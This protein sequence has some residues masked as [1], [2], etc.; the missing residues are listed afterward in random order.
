MNYFP[1]RAKYVTP[2][3]FLNELRQVASAVVQAFRRASHQVK[4]RKRLYASSLAF[5][6]ALAL[7]PALA[8]LMA[9]LAGDAFTQKR[10]QIL[11][12]IVD[13]IYPVEEVVTDAGAEL[14]GPQELKK[15]REVGRTKIH[16]TVKKFA[17][18]A[19]KMGLA[20]LAAFAVVVFLLL[21][22]VE[23]SFNFLWGVEKSRHFFSQFIRHTVFLIATPFLA[24]LI[25]VLKGWADGW[26]WVKAIFD[27]RIFS[28]A[29]LFGVIWMTCAWMYKRVPNAKTYWRPAIWAGLLTTLLL[30]A[31][32]WGMSWYTLNAVQNSRVY[33]ALWMI[34]VILLWFYLCWTILLFGA[35]TAFF[36]QKKKE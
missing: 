12:K 28:S 24:V 11:D 32:R 13:A 18:H 31:A 10:D 33:G 23:D 9:V 7:V 16:R 34:P 27:S 36:I 30:E 6:T 35:E 15:L 22:D 1:N 4:G 25:L 29:L 14:P 21:R 2:S 5:K 3:G 20:G 17:R 19:E 26:P 8:I